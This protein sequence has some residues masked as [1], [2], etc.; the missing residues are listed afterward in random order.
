M[1]VLVRR[2]TLD[3]LIVI[4]DVLW[5]TWVDSYSHF[6]SE[7]DLKGYF[8]EHYD[9]DSLRSLYHNPL[10]DG[11]VGLE[12]DKIVGFMRTAREPE[13]NRYYV[14]SIYVLPQFQ[15]HGIGRA[16]MVRAAEEARGFKLDRLWVGVMVQNTQAG[17]WY[18]SMGYEIVRTEP[19]VMGKSTV[20]HYIGFIKL[21]SIR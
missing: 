17:D 18:K 4:Q 9:L 14:S 10:A 3:D 15:G 19:F 11:F 6:I 21:E 16:L 5:K 7:E 13:E 12:D 2:W 1:K 20:D 8:S